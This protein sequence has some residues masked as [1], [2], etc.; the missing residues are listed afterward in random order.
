MCVEATLT[1]SDSPGSFQRLTAAN[2]G[3]Q[4]DRICMAS[5]ELLA[6]SRSAGQYQAPDQ[7]LLLSLASV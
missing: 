2:N 7:S 1:G 6:G 5:S 3:S 4:A